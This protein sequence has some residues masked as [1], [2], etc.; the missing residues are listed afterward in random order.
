MGNLNK[1]HFWAR[2]LLG[3]QVYYLVTTIDKGYPKE[4]G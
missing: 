4:N 1:R 3:F 2:D